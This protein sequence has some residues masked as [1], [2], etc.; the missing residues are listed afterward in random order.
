MRKLSILLFVGLA[1]SGLINFNSVYSQNI[2]NPEAEYSRIR[3]M[4]FDGDLTGAATAAR[5]LVKTYP[6]YGD[7]RILLGRI[8][9]WQ[10]E[11]YQAAAVIDTLLKKEPN[12]ADALAA[13]KDISLWS[14]DNTA[15][16]TDIRTGYSFDS[17]TEPYTRYWQVFNLAAGHRFI[18]GP[19]SG[20]INVG[21]LITDK[22]TNLYA[23]ELQLEV[24]MYPTI[25]DKNY[26]YLA[27][28]F[29]PGIY[30]PKHR[31]AIEL[32]QILPAGFAISAG[33]NYYYFDRNIYIAL[34]SVEK[35]VRKYWF[36]G[37]CFI[38]F[39]DEGPTTS[40][41]VNAR[42]YFNDFDY[43][44]LTLG[45]GTAPDEP[46]DIQSDIMRLSA[47]SIRIAYNFSVASRF[48]VRLGAGYSRE[49][50]QESV[51]RDRFEGNIK[52]IY[53]IKMK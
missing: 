46:F 23:T 53:A 9:A 50:Y 40:F 31:A 51:M 12:N 11:Y 8:L 4:A 22:E 39:K 42:R 45:M 38:Y 30:F 15:I 41:Y 49:E 26:A 2:Q 10:K 6:A 47:K 34:V 5:K 44:Q 52:M 43:L 1:I 28:A 18:W 16:A 17:F 3:T 32:W 29:S 35:Y 48:S 27:Y 25:S 14:K 21:N 37:K 20:G 19:A 24:E 13:K 36:S 7:A 33:L